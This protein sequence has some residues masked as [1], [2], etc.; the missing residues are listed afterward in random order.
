MCVR[1]VVR[2]IM[3][4]MGPVGC[5]VWVIVRCVRLWGLLSIVPVVCRDTLDRVLLYVHHAH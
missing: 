1:H 5:V 3:C 2:A 4:L